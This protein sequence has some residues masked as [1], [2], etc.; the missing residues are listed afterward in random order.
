MLEYRLV[1][2][3]RNVDLLPEQFRAIKVSYNDT[4]NFYK[5]LIEIKCFTPCVSVK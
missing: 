4:L 2:H 3:E 1:K 5:I